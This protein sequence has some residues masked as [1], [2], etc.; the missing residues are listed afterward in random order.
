[1]IFLIAIILHYRTEG[2]F[3]LSFVIITLINEIT[4]V[5]K[6]FQKLKN[7][8]HVGIQICQKP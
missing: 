6:N 2:S 7:F 8:F 5:L 4:V 1:M 3:L